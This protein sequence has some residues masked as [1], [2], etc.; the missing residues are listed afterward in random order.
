MD[1]EDLFIYLVASDQTVSTVLIKEED[2]I[3]RQIFY[4]SQVPKGAEIKYPNIEKVAL[5]LLLVVRKF[6]VYLENYQGI[7]VIDQPLRRIL[8]RLKMLGRMLAWSV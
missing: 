4:V 7:V 3:Q 6:K 5:A 8:Q 1:G 2:G